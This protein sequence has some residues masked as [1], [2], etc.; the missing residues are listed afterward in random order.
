VTRPARLLLPQVACPCH[1]DAYHGP[2]HA[3][4]P[5]CRYFRRRLLQLSWKMVVVAAAEMVVAAA[6]AA[7]EVA[8][9]I[10]LWQGRAPPPA[11]GVAVRLRRRR[12]LRRPT[13]PQMAS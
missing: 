3:P 10:R 4:M 9:E 1:P 11:R 12:E 6:A 8:V 2:C 7:M 13:V 5:H